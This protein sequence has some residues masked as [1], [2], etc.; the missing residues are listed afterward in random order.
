MLAGNMAS[1]DAQTDRQLSLLLQR[2]QAGDRRAYEHFL[3]QT[4]DIVRN[5][6]RHQLRSA[7]L[8]DDA[9]Q[10][11]LL[12]LHRYRHTYD[13]A[14]PIGPWIRAIAVNRARDLGRARKRQQAREA[15]D[16]DWETHMR[17]GAAEEAVRLAFL[18]RALNGLSA[19]QRDI[20]CL[21]KFAGY[22]VAEIAERTGRS[23]SAVK[24]TAHR[25]YRALR[26]LLTR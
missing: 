2:A 17:G 7:T 19:A 11:T 25:G 4:R 20:I 18:R 24:V 23:P 13:P 14:R 12:S 16:W 8:L 9:V 26:A 21:L 22:S 10:E 1:V 3:R 6:L 5:L 15:L